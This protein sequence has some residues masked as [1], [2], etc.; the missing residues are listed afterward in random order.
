MALNLNTCK[1][2]WLSKDARFDGKFFIGV[3]TTG[4]Y[5]R[6]IC[7]VKPPKLKNVVFLKT[8]AQAS[9]QG[10]RPC[11]RCR[12]ETSPGTPVWS[13]TCAIVSRAL[14]LIYTGGLNNTSA[15]E[16]SDR[17]GISTRHLNR[18]FMTHL[19]A[20]PN[21]VAQ[22]QRLHFAKRLLDETTLPMI[23]VALAAGYG[24]LRRFNDHIKQTYGIT[25]SQLRK[26]KTAIM[27]AD[28]A[29]KYVFKLPYRPPYN[30]QHLLNF[31][32]TRAT[33]GVE[34]V[35][36]NEYTRTIGTADNPGLLKVSGDFENNQLICE[37][38]STQTQDLL[39]TIE[40]VKSTFDLGA[41]P[42]SIANCL[43]ADK[44]LWQQA[45]KNP[46]LRVPGCWDGFE[47]AVRSIT[48]QQVSVVGATTVMGRIVKLYGTPCEHSQSL[49]HLFPTPQT[50]AELDPGLLSMPKARAMTIATVAKAVALGELCFR[51]CPGQ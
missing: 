11:L 16:F 39:A 4:I 23:E 21:A 2:A 5:C 33:P 31:L 10:F 48:G 28:S 14:R 38:H 44:T 17:L 12:P 20:S 27:S 42:E 8:A 37:I 9:T 34:Q 36:D 15:L 43:K 46:G 18:L 26:S 13:G 22:N 6:P 41:D 24:S 49:S 25:P 30:W 45:K 1:Q 29:H 47:I 3:K 7:P 19:G 32:S 35:V 40:S 50:L 51:P